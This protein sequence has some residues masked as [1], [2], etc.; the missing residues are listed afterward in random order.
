MQCGCMA[1]GHGQLN[2]PCLA[3]ICSPR[4]VCTT[5]VSQINNEGGGG[6]EYL[7]IGGKFGT[8]GSENHHHHHLNVN[9]L[10]RLIKG[11]DSCFQT[12]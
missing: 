10:P 2:Y 3:A 6:K 11:M 1:H 9:F 4:K 8:R 7:E 5:G 12:A